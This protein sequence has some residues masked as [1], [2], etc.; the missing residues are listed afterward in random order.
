MQH[1]EADKLGNTLPPFNSKVFYPIY[2]EFLAQLQQELDA[3]NGFQQYLD[4]MSLEASRWLPL[5]GPRNAIYPIPVGD[6]VQPE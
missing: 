6:P 3:N 5:V 1:I 4:E 2:V